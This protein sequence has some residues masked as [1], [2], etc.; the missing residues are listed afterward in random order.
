[1]S[2]STDRTKWRA[3]ARAAG[4]VAVFAGSL[5]AGAAAPA[6]ANDGTARHLT[7]DDNIGVALSWSQ[8]L[9]GAGAAPEALL[10]RD[11]VFADSLTSG[12]L[13][14]GGRPLLLTRSDALDQRVADELGRLGTTKVHVLGGTAAIGPA[15]TD[16]LENL[17]IA[18]ERHSG[19]TRIDTAVAV[20]EEVGG[21]GGTAILGRAFASPGA[22]PSQAFADSLAAGAWAAAEQWPVL[23][24]ESTRLSAPTAQQI[25]AANYATLVIV[26]GTAAVSA[27][28]EA[29]VRALG[30][31][32]QRVA[33]DDRFETALRIAEAFAGDPGTTDT[34]I[35][36]DG[37]GADSWADGFA[38]A[39]AGATDFPIVLT[40]GDQVP[41][42]TAGWLQGAADGSPV[43]LV[44]G[45]S[46]TEPA[47]G[48]A[49]ETLG[50]APPVPTSPTVITQAL[51]LGGLHYPRNQF[52]VEPPHAPYCDADHYHSSSRVYPVERGGAA[53]SN[54][55]DC[56]YGRT[57]EVTVTTIEVS[58]A[59]WEA[60]R[61]RTD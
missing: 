51:V 5:V 2:Q 54:P 1:M 11:D 8:L 34:V 3:A 23:L 52:L 42:E 24:T 25:E 26:G 9:H 30:P 49:A 6:G 45:S 41:P 35:V 47:C 18:W 29:E 40:N 60:Y 31:E 21:Q 32:V 53:L 55:P 13:Q 14:G 43:D 59:D 7:A 4:A 22:D 44:C 20:A 19:Q 46:T 58:R 61:L 38:A 16:A 50:L 57:R 33:G 28:V 48:S 37:T 17:G 27:E 56:G 15:V 10:G 36:V 39:G 12:G